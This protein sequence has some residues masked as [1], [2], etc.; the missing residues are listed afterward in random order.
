MLS[1]MMRPSSTAAVTVSKRSS[2]R[3]IAAASFATSVPRMPIATPISAFRRAG[4]SLTPSPSMATI[5]PRAWR[6]CTSRSLC[7]GVMRL[8]APIC[9]SLAVNSLSDNVSSSRPSMMAWPSLSRFNSR[10]TAAAVARWSPVNI[11]V[12]RPAA[13]NRTIASFTPSAGG[14]AKPTRP[15]NVSR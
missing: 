4:A 13:R 9:D 14:S 10:P 3:T 7:C 2:C 12:R 6:A 11:T 15:T 5:S 8:K 1:K